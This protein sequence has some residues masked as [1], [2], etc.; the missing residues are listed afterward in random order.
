MYLTVVKLR[1]L[2][3]RNRRFFGNYYRD[4]NL[5]AGLLWRV[6]ER[7]PSLY[8]DET[9]CEKVRLQVQG[10]RNVART[11]IIIDGDTWDGAQTVV[12]PIA[13]RGRRLQGFV[14]AALDPDA[15]E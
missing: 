12:V 11:S 2:G 9:W 5:K 1:R 6:A 8:D 14:C 10:T 7:R 13:P 3:Y 15:I 4:R